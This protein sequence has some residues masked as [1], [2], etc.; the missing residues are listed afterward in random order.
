[1]QPAG[2]EGSR[3]P[4]QP[5]CNMDNYPLPMCDGVMLV[6]GKG[7][8]PRSGKSSMRHPMV[9]AYNAWGDKKGTDLYFSSRWDQNW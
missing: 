1:M 5:L 6:S 7:S 2:G 9:Y 8:G 3:P 4:W